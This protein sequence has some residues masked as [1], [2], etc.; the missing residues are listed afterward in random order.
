MCAPPSSNFLC[1]YYFSRAIQLLLP[2]LV[3]SAARLSLFPSLY[4]VR[5]ERDRLGSLANLQFIFRNNSVAMTRVYVGHIPYEA[6]E[7]DVER[8][9]KGYGKIRDILMKRG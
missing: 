3:G 1:A 7:R 9:F 2:F 5:A 8:F 6:R 4:F